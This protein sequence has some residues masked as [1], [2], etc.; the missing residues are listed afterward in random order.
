MVLD[1]PINNLK[2]VIAAIQIEFDN[3][4]N[5]GKSF[6]VKKEILQRLRLAINELAQI[7]LGAGDNDL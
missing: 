4:V 2:A 7:E 6:Y 1:S 3:A 5:A